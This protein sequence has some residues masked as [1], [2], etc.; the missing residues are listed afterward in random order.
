MAKALPS[1]AGLSA[2]GSAYRKGG[3]ASASYSGIGTAMASPF[4]V[5][6]ETAKEMKS[7]AGKFWGALTKNKSILGINLGIGSLLKQSQVF[8]GA[9]STIMQIIGAMVDVLIAPWIVPLFIPLAKKMVSFI[10]KIREWSADLAE[11]YVPK[12]KAIF[13][14][15]VTGEGTLWERIGEF[16]GESWNLIWEDT[17][18]SKWWNEQT[19]IL[20]VFTKTLSAAGTGLAK[21][22]NFFANIGEGPFNN[23]WANMAWNAISVSAS[24]AAGPMSSRAVSR[25]FNLLESLIEGGDPAPDF[26]QIPTS[27]P[28]PAAFQDI[29]EKS[30]VGLGVSYDPYGGNV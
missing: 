25:L 26:P 24:F 6:A 7:P 2:I 20:G 21:V 29:Y 1:R 15:L 8:T 17:G 30:G 4:K 18:L 14:N 5:L 9:V 3:A 10:P 11:K 19:G 13:D 23:Y 22:Y 27:P 12:I 28:A 16:I